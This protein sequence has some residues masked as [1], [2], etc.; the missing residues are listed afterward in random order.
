MALTNGTVTDSATPSEA[1]STEQL[2][3][4]HS[5][6]DKAK[7]AF[8]LLILRGGT[9]HDIDCKIVESTIDSNTLPYEAVSYTW[10]PGFTADTVNINGKKLPIT[11]NLSLI[12]RDLRF[13]DADRVIWVDAI[14]IDQQDAT[15]KGH[16]VGQMQDIFALAERV[17][18]C[19]ARPT[20]Y[21]D[22]LLGSL[23]R[24]QSGLQNIDPDDNSAIGAC[25]SKTQTAI[26]RHHL[27]SQPQPP[28]SLLSVQLEALTFLQRQ[29]LEYILGQAWFHRVWILQEV[30]NARDALVYCGQKSVSAAVFALGAR[31]LEYS[32]PNERRKTVIGV[33]N[34]MPGHMRK[35]PSQDLLNLFRRFGKANA[36]VE[37]DR[38]YALFGI[39][40][41]KQIQTHIPPDY[42]K[43]EQEVIIDTIAY[44]CHCEIS[45]IATSPYDSIDH[46]LSTSDLFGNTLLSH[47][48]SSKNHKGALSV[49]QRHGSSISV[50]PD[51]LRMA[52]N[53]TMMKEGVM[54]QLLEQRNATSV[55]SGQEGRDS[56][57]FAAEYGYDALVR[58]LLEKGVFIEA[59][60]PQE[61][62]QRGKHRTPLILASMNGHETVVKILLEQG[63]SMSRDYRCEGTPVAWAARNGH[64]SVV[65]LLVEEG[66][67]IEDDAMESRS[68]LSWAASKGHEAI[69]RL[70]LKHGADPNREESGKDATPL[71]RA[72][73][74]GR[75]FIVQII[76]ES[77]LKFDK[78][79]IDFAMMCAARAAQNSTGSLLLGVEAS[80]E[81]L[82]VVGAMVGSNWEADDRRDDFDA[83]I[84]ML[85]AKCSHFHGI[86]NHLVIAAIAGN[87]RMVRPFLA[88]GAKIGYICT[89]TLDGS[90][91]FGTALTFAIRYGH[92]DVAELLLAGGAHLETRNQDEETPLFVA[93][94]RG[95]EDI[96]EMLLEKGADIEVKNS[97][98]ETPLW[99]AVDKGREYIVK[100]LLKYGAAVQTRGSRERT[101]LC[102]AADKGCEDTVRLLLENG[103]DIE[104]RD[105]DSQTAL[106]LAAYKGHKK[107]VEVL[108][109]NGAD[110]EAKDCYH[111]TPLAVAKENDKQDVV[112]LLLESG[113]SSSI[114]IVQ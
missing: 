76:L 41:D 47:F 74:K 15:E 72:A 83:I 56:L 62:E 63:A 54:S 101:P 77:R 26:A 75:K 20:D 33:L 111:F 53:E 61:D 82:D 112:T 84:M 58:Q 34:L 81:G 92:K 68:P 36:S 45:V 69:V 91:R 94:R 3:Y 110:V 35:N 48:L 49:L 8:R 32:L 67:N 70:L 40:E 87:E 9:G 59:H 55:F 28:E 64:S 86:S 88:Y 108:L 19:I 71:S 79:C 16:Q 5:T 24:L 31:L 97:V 13:A 104:S 52:V 42:N 99:L 43:S 65:Q 102:L 21:T 25:W 30:A 38:I 107:V 6:I 23:E 27:S 39:C 93:V 7:R 113:A 95:H 109:A 100:V 105:R 37:R 4:Q 114:D 78:S 73:E 60:N 85:C 103:A 10:G 29:G 11:F 44:I 17:L 98:K 90:R 51:M 2:V 1:V 50:S 46:F 89:R 12:L 80:T 66:S 18:F 14:C 22:L 106:S 96:V 57:L